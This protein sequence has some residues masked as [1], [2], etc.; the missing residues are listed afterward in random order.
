MS[1]A[2]YIFL[3]EVI[4]ANSQRSNIYKNFEFSKKGG[5]KAILDLL[6]NIE[7]FFNLKK[8]RIRVGKKFNP[9]EA[10]TAIQ[11][12]FCS[13]TNPVRLEEKEFIKIFKNTLT[14]EN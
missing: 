11:N 9:S 12:N 6:K 5:P 13:P 4:K 3:P 10:I 1:E 2:I 8:N 7:V 14:Y